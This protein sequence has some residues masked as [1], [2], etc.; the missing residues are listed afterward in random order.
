MPTFHGKNGKVIIWDVAGASRDLSG[1]FNNV[2]MS[3]SRENPT[4]TTFGQDTQ[5]RVPGVQ[6]VQFSL[7][8]VYSPSPNLS[9]ASTLGEIIAASLNTVIRWMPAGSITGCP[10][11]T[12]CVLIS[13]FEAQGPQSGIAGISATFQGSSGSLTRST[14]P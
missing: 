14:V 1:D 7:A 5:S 9:A 11:F 4:T 2:T 10:M 3:V 8:G 12:A 13:Q 6:D